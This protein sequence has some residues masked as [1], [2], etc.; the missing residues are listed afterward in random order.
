MP[1]F[2]FKRRRR[3]GAQDG[4]PTLG[5]VVPVRAL[6]TFKDVFVEVNGKKVRTG[7]EV[8]Y[9][10]LAEREAAFRKRGRPV[11]EFEDES[12]NASL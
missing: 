2:D 4:V 11:I 7:Q 10:E 8:E 5:L 3:R 12:D 9:D 6:L 1:R